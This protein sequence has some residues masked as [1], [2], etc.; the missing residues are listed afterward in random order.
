MNDGKTTAHPPKNAIVILLDSLNRHML[1]AYGGREFDTPNLDD[2]ARR[3]VRFDRHYSGSLPC[4]PARHDILC[5]AIDFLWKPWGSIEIWERPLTAYLRAAG[6]VTKLVSD[7]PH[8]FEVGGENY[9][10]DF[11]A[12]DYQRGHESDPWRPEL[13][14]RAVVRAR[15]YAVRQLARLLSR[16]GGFSGAAHDGG[17]DRVARA[18]GAQSRPLHAVRRRV[19]SARAIRHA[20]ALRVDVRFV[21]ART[22]H[23]LAAVHQRRSDPRRAHARAGAAD[24]RM[25][26]RQAHDD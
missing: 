9:H 13:D 17:C 6:V 22:A 24:S 20:G 10:T 14:W 3:A 25:L 2:F 12:W 4:I 7:H 19:R 21:V 1:G 11:T 8:L 26:R 18:L 23:D 16:R 5:G 15:A